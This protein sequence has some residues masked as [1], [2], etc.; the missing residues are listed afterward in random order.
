MAI[1]HCNGRRFGGIG[2][3]AF[4]A[5]C[6]MI[7]A[8][9]VL[10]TPEGV[11]LMAAITNLP[12]PFTQS[13]TIQLSASDFGTPGTST[14][15]TYTLDINPLNTTT[16][17]L[18]VD[19]P[20]MTTLPGIIT[21][22][23]VTNLNPNTPPYGDIIWYLKMKNTDKKDFNNGTLTLVDN[24]TFPNGTTSTDLIN[25]AAIPAQKLPATIMKV[26]GLYWVDQGN[27]HYLYKKLELEFNLTDIRFSG[28]YT[29]SIHTSISY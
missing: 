2:R 21:R 20:A 4:R 14:T 13:K 22:P 15:R 12:V 29:G 28:E 9:I 8:M 16:V 25:S 11:G 24:Y 27:E 3:A 19:V 1:P 23:V 17:D 26:P 18:N 10:A 5:G 7:A 6:G